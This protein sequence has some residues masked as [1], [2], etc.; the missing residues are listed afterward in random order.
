MIPLVGGT[1]KIV[2]FRD[3]VEQRSPPGAG[4]QEQGIS[5]KWVEFYLGQ[6]SVLEIGRR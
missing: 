3:K 6:E 2:R 4:E 5:T 1:L